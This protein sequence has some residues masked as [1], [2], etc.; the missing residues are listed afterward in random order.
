MTLNKVQIT[1]LVAGGIGFV[2][3]LL[4]NIPGLALAGS[5]ALSIFLMA[6]VFWMFEPIPIYATSLLV[7][8]LQILLLS[9]QGLIY[10]GKKLPTATPESVESQQWNVPSRA[11]TADG[12]LYLL[13]DDGETVAREVEVIARDEEAGM[14]TV[15]APF[16]YSE[17]RVAADVT[18]P[19]AEFNPNP[20][21]DFMGTLADP[22]IILF[23]GGFS[24]AGA[25][26]KYK[27]DR[28]LTRILLAPFGKRPGFI[29]MGLMSVTALLSAFMSNTATTAMMMTVIIPIIAQTQKGDPVR[30]GLALSIPF[31]ANIG[32][33]AT[34]IGTPPNAIVLANLAQQGISISFGYWMVLALPLVLIMLLVAWAV[35]NWFFPANTESIELEIKEHFRTSSKAYILYGIFLLTVL[36]WITS[37]L[38]GISS[39][40]VALIPVVGLT[41]TQVLEKEDIREL[42][43]EVLWLMAGGISLG[44]SMENTGLASWM[45]QQIG[46][47]AMSVTVLF[48]IFG[49]V[50][51]VLSNFISNTVTA[52]LVVPLAM[53]TAMSSATSGFSMIVL[54][55]VVGVSASLAMVLP[56]S[57]P[58]NAIA[59]S[60]EMVTTRQMAKAGTVIGIVGVVVTLGYALFYW[61]ILF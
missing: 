59:M 55:L 5:L 7:I 22:I 41:L 3:P 36:L 40:I 21:S 52:S 25:A 45:I 16:L 9:G 17:S 51:L 1:G 8:L 50:G 58:P 48:L 27:L 46:W 43:W 32:G 31:A 60:T 61:P 37:S 38:H 44:I 18:H 6:A 49:I 57:T 30:I 15:E 10:S 47:G 23:L 56:I 19:L 2:V 53:T 4:I 35:L 33:I 13:R 42:P 54:V 29:I 26:V 34:P 11:L 28:N 24:L 14:V 12:K 39:T 20:Y